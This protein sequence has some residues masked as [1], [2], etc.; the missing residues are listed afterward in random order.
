MVLN[1]WN[2]NGAAKKP[3]ARCRISRAGMRPFAEACSNL[4]QGR[5]KIRHCGSQIFAPTPF[6]ALIVHF[7]SDRLRMK[8]LDIIAQEKKLL[9][10][11][12]DRLRQQH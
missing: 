1:R 11:R 12:R 6:V 7:L 9:N 2:K 4:P 3:E 5:T 8:L 10:T